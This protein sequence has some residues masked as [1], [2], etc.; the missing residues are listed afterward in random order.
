MNASRPLILAL[1]LT[2]TA[3]VEFSIGTVMTAP[4]AGASAA[5]RYTLRLGDKVTIPA[6]GQRCAVYK[7]GGAPEFFC[8]RPS[9]PRHQ[10]TLFRDRIQVWKVGNPDSPVWSGKP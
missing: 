9:R 5:H 7:E 10:V 2:A 8:A 1:V 3:A 4:A 6:L